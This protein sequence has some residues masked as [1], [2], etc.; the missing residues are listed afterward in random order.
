MSKKDCKNSIWGIY[1]ILPALI[2]TFIFIII[3][4]VCSF[5]LSFTE[6]D[7]LN[8]IKFVGIFV[9]GMVIAF[10]PTKILMINKLKKKQNELNDLCRENEKLYKQNKELK[11]RTEDLEY[12][13]SK[14]RKR[15]NVIEDEKEFIEDENEQLRNKLKRK[16]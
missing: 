10:I 3:P 6:W 12:D 5:T 8:E 13:L 1:F 7:L 4:I 2:G 9:L 11:R 15:I 16:Y 14:V